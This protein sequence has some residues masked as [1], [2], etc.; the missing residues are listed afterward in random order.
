MAQKICLK[1]NL[2]I[3][4]NFILNVQSVEKKESFNVNLSDQICSL[5]YAKRLKE[6]GVKQESAFYRF[7]CK[8][9]EYIFCKYYEQYSN[10]TDLDIKNG[11]S[12]FTISEIKEILFEKNNQYI[13]KLGQLKMTIE[14]VDREFYRATNNITDHIIDDLLEVNTYA[15][16]LIL[17]LETNLYE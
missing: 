4:M 11:Y 15:K 2:K 16:L 6:L 5:E 13:E 8:D 17:F 3:K 1:L 12:A 9:H 14:V 7:E 10:N